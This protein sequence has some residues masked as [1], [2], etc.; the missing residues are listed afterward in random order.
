M[1][2]LLNLRALQRVGCALA[3]GIFCAGLAPTNFHLGTRVVA[4]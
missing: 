4:S 2:Q 3:A 1:H